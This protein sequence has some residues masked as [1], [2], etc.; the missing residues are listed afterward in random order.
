VSFDLSFCNGTLILRDDSVNGLTIMAQKAVA[1]VFL[2]GVY[3]VW[4]QIPAKSG[5]SRRVV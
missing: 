1:T 5:N 2:G 3:P 4:M